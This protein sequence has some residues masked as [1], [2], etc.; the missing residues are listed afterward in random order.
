MCS[1]CLSGLLRKKALVLSVLCFKL[2]FWLYCIAGNL[3][4][5]NT[6]LPVTKALHHHGDE[7]ER[8]GY[9]LE[10]LLLFSRSSVMQQ[11]AIG[12][13]TIANILRLV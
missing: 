4:P 5:G 1:N 3:L 10:E 12:V 7:P 2:K 8:P 13:S 9:T 6:D 11:R